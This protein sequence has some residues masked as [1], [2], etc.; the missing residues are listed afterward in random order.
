MLRQNK[1]LITQE[2]N[3]TEHIIVKQSGI[4]NK[5]VFAK[6]DLE[7]GTSI[8]E[9]VGEFIS[10]EESNRRLE[11]SVQEHPGVSELGAVYIFD[12]NDKY[13]IDGDVPYNPAK[14]INHACYPNAEVKI[15]NDK[16]FIKAIKNIA[17]G[18]EI[19]FNYGYGMEETDT[20]EDLEGFECYCNSDKCVGFMLGEDYWPKLKE[21]LKENKE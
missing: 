4:H 12:L 7:K 1:Q 13:D 20:L 10:K 5:G 19:T 21:L 8:I 2:I 15:I 9:Y 3:E 6:K 18:E 17:K 11:L 16:I 14:Y